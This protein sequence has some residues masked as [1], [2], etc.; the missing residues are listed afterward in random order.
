LA[1]GVVLG[2]WCFDLLKSLRLDEIYLLIG[3]GIKIRIR[4]P[5][6]I[7]IRIDIFPRRWGL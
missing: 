7:E 1:T 3:L 2:K 4:V 6:K 5:L